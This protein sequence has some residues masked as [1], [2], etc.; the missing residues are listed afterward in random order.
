LFKA[1]VRKFGGSTRHAEIRRNEL[2]PLPAWD[3]QQKEVLPH[4]ND[5]DVVLDIGSGHAAAPISHILTDYYPDQSRHRAR[6]AIE[7]RPLVICSVDFMPFKAKAF[8]LSMCTHVLEHIP[9]PLVAVD[10]IVRVSSKGYIETPSYG[11]D[12][13]IGTGGQHVWQVVN[14]GGYLY[15]FPY[16]DRQHQAHTESPFMSIWCQDE[17]HPLQSYFWERQD[18]FNAFQFWHESPKIQ[19]MGSAPDW[20]RRSWKPVATEELPNWEPSLTETEIARLEARLVGPDG[21]TPMRYADGAF[22]D[23]T[24]QINYPVRGKRIYFE[25]GH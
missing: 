17:Y 7:D 8:D 5:G 25:L 11:K 1:F 21:I 12:V 13:L 23:G 2:F 24:G 9:N 15:F 20:P 14:S 10:E 22:V 6:P 16:T 19:V 3:Y 4:L 18:I